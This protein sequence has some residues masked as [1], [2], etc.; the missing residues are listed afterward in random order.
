M[1]SG[2]CI[3]DTPLQQ[4]AKGDDVNEKILK[5]KSKPARLFSEIGRIVFAVYFFL[6]D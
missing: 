1:C 3:L 6:M 2:A 4:A 5:T